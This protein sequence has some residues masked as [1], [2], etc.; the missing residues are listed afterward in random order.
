MARLPRVSAGDAPLGTKIA[1]HFTRK[2]MREM[3]ACAPRD[4]LEPLEVFANVPA[5]MKGYGRFEQTAAK[6]H[7]LDERHRTL[8][9]L[10]AAAMTE[11]EYCIDIGS[12]VARHRGISD[13]E[14]LA[15]PTHRQSALFSDVDKLVLDYAAG[16]SRTPV[17]VSDDRFASLQ[18]HFKT[19]QLVELTFAIALENF[20]G[21]FN[22][23]LGIGA[24]GFSKGRVCVLPATAT[25]TGTNDAG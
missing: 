1:Y 23:A 6:V 10:K 16:M 17:E 15:L 21:R 19:E 20:R 12:Q 4:M 2:A 14:L 18:E 25:A 3:A 5:L 22:L 8:A 24:A 9:E 13:E 7:L 11:C